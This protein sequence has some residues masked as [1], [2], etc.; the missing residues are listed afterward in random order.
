VKRRKNSSLLSSDEARISFFLIN[1]GLFLNLLCE[2]FQVVELGLLMEFIH[3]I[4]NFMSLCLLQ[5]YC[6]KTVMKNN[7]K[8]G[9]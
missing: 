6:C 9:Q 3:F 1:L 8:M 4:K 5:H 7:A 2:G